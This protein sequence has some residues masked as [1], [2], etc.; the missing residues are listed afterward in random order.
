MTAR[1]PRRLSF[2]TR[3]SLVI[4][5]VFVA[6]GGSL[7][8]VQYFVVQ[9]LFASASQVTLSSCELVTSPAGA[10]FV[11][12]DG[13]TGCATLGTAEV[14]GSVDVEGTW[15]PTDAARAYPALTATDAVL[16]QTRFLSDEVIG[17][18]LGW[19]IALLAGFAGI[20]AA[21]AFWLA[22]R[23][24]SRIGEVTATA[25]D[26]SERDLGRRLA[27]PG[28]DDEVK[29][30]GDTIDGMLDRLQT[31]FAAQ[32]RFVA[33]ASHELR[34]PLTTT[35]AALEIPLEHGD[36]PAALEPAI[37]TALRATEQSE[38]LI[39]ALLSL[40][41]GRVDP[42][43]FEPV[44]LEPLVAEEL[45]ELGAAAASRDIAVEPRLEPVVVAGDAALLG[46]AVRNLLENAIRHNVDG[47]LLRVRLSD[48]GL[49]VENTGEVL[50]P[51][52]IPLL[53]E[54]FYRGA[55]SRISEGMGLGL[56]IVESVALT[57][58]GALH[59][60]AREGGGLVARLVLPPAG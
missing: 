48:A 36:V 19:S 11:L 40:A 41:R 4:A 35:R 49:E 44:D 50:D 25:R 17:G 43:G 57:H 14:A 33:N 15:E 42:D 5:L 58:G 1:R 31:A 24:L 45:A 53:T 28:P 3:L 7:L 38:R 46:R 34:T 18:L 22:R 27:L 21:I 2:R 10:A 32:H 59:L 26:I 30:L 54:P 37:R 9:G 20:A 60:A 13:A 51:E 23:S 52:S 8:A 29:E 16:Q 39:A 55:G 6:A 12:A 47:G 56:P